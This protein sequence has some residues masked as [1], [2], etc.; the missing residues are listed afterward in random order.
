MASSTEVQQRVVN[1]VCSV[2][3]V[4]PEMVELNSNFVFDLGAE[5]IQSVQLVAAFEHEFDVE[6]DGEQALAVQTVGDA[7]EFIS[8]HLG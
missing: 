2:L 1:V 4:A 6:L 3:N 8:G 5:S 7:V